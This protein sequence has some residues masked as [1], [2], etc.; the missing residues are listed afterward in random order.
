MTACDSCVYSETK[1]PRCTLTNFFFSCV[2]WQLYS[3]E[4]HIHAAILPL[5]RHC[6]YSTP[7]QTTH[8]QPVS[9]RN[10]KSPTYCSQQH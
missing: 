7:P 3:L 9:N 1:N 8:S 5:K 4:Q 10:R 2:Q 6:R